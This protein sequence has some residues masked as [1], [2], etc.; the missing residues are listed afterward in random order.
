MSTSPW[1]AEPTDTLSTCLPGVGCAGPDPRVAAVAGAPEEPGAPTHE[2]PSGVSPGTDDPS[3]S[4]AP[5]CW[6]HRPAGGCVG[7]SDVT[8]CIRAS[9]HCPGMPCC[10]VS[11]PPVGP[12]PSSLPEALGS[13]VSRSGGR[14]PATPSALWPWPLQQPPLQPRGVSD[15]VL[16]GLPRPLPSPSFLPSPHLCLLPRTGHSPGGQTPPSSTC[17]SPEV[18]GAEGAEGQGQGETSESY[19]PSAPPPTAPPP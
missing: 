14:R 10:M 9:P 13:V 12:R 3:T 17:G 2:D 8:A 5:P 4:L 7:W 6:G 15:L 18:G 1:R 19:R 11:D 16:E